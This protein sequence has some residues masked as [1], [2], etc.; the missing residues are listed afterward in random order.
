MSKTLR[1]WPLLVLIA[2]S[3]LLSACRKY[4]DG[5]TF[6]LR[7]KRE[8]VINNWSARSIFR[9]E[10]NETNFFTEYN[11][12]FQG[13]N[14]W[15]WR[16]D[17]SDDSLPPTELTGQWQLTASNTLIEVTF[18]EP[19]LSINQEKLFFEIRRL[20]EDELWVGYLFNEDVY[21]VQMQ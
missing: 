13:N 20:A 4:E 12:Q 2:G 6:A 9:N 18:D 5:P 3:L 8:R 14:R 10:I 21:S 11:M 19:V 1:F 15:L 17:R 7:S 16:F